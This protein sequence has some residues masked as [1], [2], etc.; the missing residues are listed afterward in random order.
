M[1]CSSALSVSC[2]PTCRPQRLLSSVRS[3][4]M[5]SLTVTMSFTE[6]FP[7]S[8]ASI[9]RS[10]VISLTVS[11]GYTCAS[12]SFSK[13]ASPLWRSSTSAAGAATVG[14]AAA[15]GTASAPSASS[16]DKIMGRNFE[17]FM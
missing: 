1:H 8:T 7:S 15:A 4:F 6:I 3:V 12:A 14:C 13:S 5:A 17:F 9:A 11:A 16:S 2:S 10:A